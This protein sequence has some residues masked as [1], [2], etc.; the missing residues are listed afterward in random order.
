MVSG[1]H[2]LSQRRQCALLRLARSNLYHRPVGESAE[3]QLFMEIID[4]Q[5]LETP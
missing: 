4:R 1:D 5:V 2:D 3:N